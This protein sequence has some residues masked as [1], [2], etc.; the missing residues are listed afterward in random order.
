MKIL[1]RGKLPDDTVHRVTCNSCNTLFEFAL[2]EATLK[3]DFRDGDYY[4]IKCP[5][6]HERVG[7][8]I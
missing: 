7:V 8:S 5:L 2:K 1:R 3:P 4:E 6:C